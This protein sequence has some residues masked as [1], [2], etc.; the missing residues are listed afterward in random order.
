MFAAVPA[1]AQ[2]AATTETITVTAQKRT[3][4]IKEVPLN[5]TVLSGTELREQHIADITDLS[6]EVPGLSF[7]NEGGSGLSKIELRGISSDAGSP[8]VGI[9]LD[10]VPITMRNLLNTGATEPQ[11]FDLDRIEV[12]RGPQGTLYGASSLGGTI[13]FI[14]KQP[15][16][17]DF[18]GNI[19][20]ELSGTKHG[21]LNYEE[22]GVVNMPLVKGLSALRLGFDYLDN[23]GYIDQRSPTTGQVT[24]DDIND[25]K[26]G[27][28]RATL[29][30]RLNDDLTVTPAVFFQRMRVDDTS[31]YD[32]SLPA[33]STEKLVA[34]RGRDTLFV[35][36]I[37]LDYDLHWA[38]LTSVSSYFWRQF[39]RVQDGTY[40][41]SVLL[42]DTLAGDP[43]TVA[44]FPHVDPTSIGN[45]PSPAYIYPTTRQYSEELRLASKSTQESGLPFTWI[46]GLYFSDQ[47][48]HLSDQE[49]ITGVGAALQ[50]LYGT[51]SV[52]IPVIADPLT[53]D[54]VYS[55]TDSYDE[56]QYAVFGE[57][58][59]ELVETIHLTA[60]LRYNFARESLGGTGGGYYNADA[61]PQFGFNSRS[62]AATPKFAATWD[63]TD[64]STLYANASKGFR[65]G[66]PN[67]PIPQFECS[68]DFQNLGV[69]GAPEK[70]N[71]DS[72]WSYELGDKARMLGN[73][74][75]VDAAIYYIT[76]KNVQQHIYLPVCGF[77]Y[78]TNAGNAES[79]GTEVSV[80]ARVTPELSLTGSASY[81]HSTLTEAEPG[82]GAS[83]GDKLL[84]TPDW[85]ATFGA[86]Y[87]HAVSDG[88]EGFVRADWEWTGASH[89]AFDNSDPDYG[90]PVYNV[91]NASIGADMGSMV[92]TLFAK[93]LLNQNK[94]IQRPS[95][96]SVSEGYTVRPLTVGVSLSKD[97]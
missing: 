84:G 45:L 47:H 93:N 32:L 8:T 89:G 33:L 54:L 90:R 16:L 1:L 91:L 62:Y 59:Y 40:Y 37:T 83:V 4:D 29:K 28:L 97:F 44:A 88:V 5:I 14:S 80:R 56:R 92:V 43:A 13:R 36:S 67:Q 72:L 87:T 25:E 74:L 17:D 3:E 22:S 85:T 42:A 35:P 81:T 41:N 79:Y 66:A 2:T 96:L 63:M 78:T 64:T 20:S 71:S 10:E 46:G 51:S 39:N 65:L 9:Y 86:E 11:F 49:F 61:A 50:N 31:V 68:A 19:Y 24:N 21:G 23:N 15:D 30:A 52:N 58:T 6:R 7:S 76:W 48:V 38:D 26:T 70:Y 94:T 75:T 60:G 12:L 53:N 82:L 69:T 95:L 57:V 27:V 73:R 77:D 34:E 55:N 18:G